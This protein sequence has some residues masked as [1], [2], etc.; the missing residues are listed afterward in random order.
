M[1]V[2]RFGVFEADLQAGE[3]RKKGRKIRLQDQPFRVL[4][5]L[6]QRPRQVVTREELRQHLW[7]DEVFVDFDHSL[8]MA[9]KKIREVL[10]DS[11]TNSR[12]VETLP[13]KTR[14]AIRS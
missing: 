12:F 6:L 11:A 10:G 13:A 14:G 7:G 5:F 9:V 1:S 3:L 8:N 2:L 4:A